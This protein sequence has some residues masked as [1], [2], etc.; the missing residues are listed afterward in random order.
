MPR[1]ER[2]LDVE[3]GPLL[4]FATKLRKLREQ[5]GSPTYR[6]LARRAHYSIATLS[7]AA[8][9][10]QLPTL[11]VT[12][13]YVRAC[14]GDEREWERIWRR[15]AAECAAGP[16]PERSEETACAPY[17]GLKPFQQADAGMFFGRESLTDRLAEHLKKKRLL[18]LLGASG[19][20]KSSVLRAG[21]LPR[22][23]ADLTLVFTPGPDPLE[24]C[25][26]QLAAR[27]GIAPGPLRADLAAEPRT[28]HRLVRQI[29]ARSPETRP[30]IR[31]ESRQESQPE[32][33]QE[34]LLVVDQFEEVFTQCGDAEERDAFVASLLHA[35]QTPDSR[36]RVVL[37]VRSDFYT[38]CTRVPGLVDVLA[39]AHV[40]VGPM[41]VDE[42]RAAIVRPAAR[43]GLTVEGA[44]LAAL[45]TAAHGR[46]GTLPLLSH[47]L[48][49]TW[50][51]RRGN[52][53]T[54]AAFQAAGGFEGALAQTAEDLYS[55]LSDTQQRIARQ[56]F[57][58]LIALG[59]GTEDTKRRVP[60]QELDDTSDVA[61]VLEQAT[62]ARLLTVDR[63]R[64][65]ITHEAL[66]GC[67][68]RLG[69][70]LGEDREHL[71][72]HRAL[73]EATAI[74]ESLDHH[75]DSL[76]RG[77]RLAAV[78]DLPE[79]VLTARER[80][81]LDASVR[82]EEAE[83]LRVRRY[84][85]RLR[86]LVAALV[87]LLV[88]A[89]TAVGVAVHFQRISVAQRNQAVALK[90][91]DT[92]ADLRIR[93][94]SLATQLALTA[95]RLK[96]GKHSRSGLFNVMSRRL[97]SH[98][99]SL[100][101]TRDGRTLAVAYDDDRLELWDLEDP[102][103][104]ALLS[105]RDSRGE[106]VGLAL[107]TFSPR[108]NFLAGVGWKGEIRLWD[109]SDLR[110]PRVLSVFPTGHKDYVFSLD[111][112]PDG[113]MIATGSYDDT[114]RLWDV[115]DPARPRFLKRLTGHTGNVKPVAFSPD[116]STLAS[117]S[118]D[119]TVRLWDVRNA[120]HARLIT[121]LGGGHQDF[122]DALAYSRDGHSLLTG[123]DDGTARLWDLTDARH[124]MRG[125]LSGHTSVVTSVGYA[126]P[127]G[128]TAVTASRDGT[129]RIWNTT[130][131]AHPVERD[132]LALS[133]GGFFAVLPLP[134]R[135][136]IVTHSQDGA[137]DIWNTDLS[138]TL[139][140]ACGQVRTP[141]SRAEWSRHFPG[142]DYR[143]PC[144][145][146]T[147]PGHSALGRDSPGARTP[148]QEGQWLSRR[149]PAH[150]TA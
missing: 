108:G 63:D 114:V 130:D 125:R 13:A 51:R 3:A 107:V 49:E 118:D 135:G 64:V 6:D 4:D 95:H 37:A 55:G 22:F 73:T 67:W 2:P 34:L 9:G 86:R 93:D 28:L 122:V 112:S 144:V 111:V 145:G 10:R 74:W 121:V 46:P 65:E 127:D 85:R 148:A 5:A 129:V 139:T 98:V 57:L 19:S 120:R 58:R 8:G 77:V 150:G 68:P 33:R 75:P 42:L 83:A 126:G 94:L 131:L 105:H 134:S 82:A 7:G 12:L 89:V 30:E 100:S 91:V 61:H 92:S 45:T 102:R 110:R 136:T 72:L 25:A 133:S 88:C 106:D 128:R 43:A 54:L 32:S 39:D 124:P 87:A 62:R 117:G 27:A 138:W 50:H 24:E 11:D 143:P 15:T 18:V 14:G 141:I 137:V 70:W 81:F 52:A 35:A 48:R 84:L 123:S 53:L 96:P 78:R 113:R 97:S 21:V 20:G 109:V 29:L 31:P 104:P 1:R 47:A 60:R 69:R 17:V 80:A 115:A 103:N 146:R 119:R 116:G 38:H 101:V 41:T 149:S 16:A 23:P 36:C 132:M 66:I 26:I 142:L 76:Y 140:H 79:D 40:P 59:E 56:L 99:H 71:R 147:R 44:L 90:A